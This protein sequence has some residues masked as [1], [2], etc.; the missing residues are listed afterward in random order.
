MPVLVL[1]T[2]VL[3]ALSCAKGNFVNFLNQL[4]PDRLLVT[5]AVARELR[6]LVGR[7]ADLTCAGYVLSQSWV[8]DDEAGDNEDETLAYEEI[9][10]KISRPSDP[11]A[12]HMGE[13]SVIFYTQQDPGRVAVLS[14]RD[15]REFAGN[16]K[17]P[18]LTVHG[19]FQLFV[20]KGLVDC[21]DA[22]AGFERASKVSKLPPL[23]VEELCVA[24]C[25][26]H[27]PAI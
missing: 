23:D 7:R 12:M 26:T 3:I 8:P 18:Y 10:D 2:D 13:A 17:I 24:G 19:V 20:S 9:R 5:A 1:D 6:S 4:F 27:Q 11:S 21:S 14:D 16:N 15:A 22:H 25:S